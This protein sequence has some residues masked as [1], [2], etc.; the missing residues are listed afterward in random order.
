MSISTY[1]KK[2]KEEIDMRKIWGNVKVSEKSEKA[3]S[4][5]ALLGWFIVVFLN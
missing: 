5:K 3:R 4:Y 2:E 1:N